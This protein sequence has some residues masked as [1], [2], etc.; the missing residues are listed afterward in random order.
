MNW[1]LGSAIFYAWFLLLPS[2]AFPA[3]AA[4]DPAVTSSTQGVA[5]GALQNIFQRFESLTSPGPL[6]QA[7]AGLDQPEGCGNCHPVVRGLSNEFCLVCH[8]SIGKRIENKIGLHGT[9]TGNC[10]T[11]H[12]EHKGRGRSLIKLDQKTFDH[13]STRYSLQGAHRTLAC[14][15]CHLSQKGSQP[16]YQIGLPA[17]CTTCHT[18]PHSANI[19]QDCTACHTQNGWRP[20]SPLKFNHQTQTRFPLQGR[21]LNATCEQCHKDPK[22]FRNTP[23][24]CDA[25]HAD[26]HA[27]QFK[28]QYCDACHSEAGFKRPSL[29]FNH[30]EMTRFTLT[31]R[32]AVVTCE[33]CHAGMKK[34]RVLTTCA[35]CHADPHKGQFGTSTACQT[36]HQ[37]EDWKGVNL[38]F[39][40]DANSRFPLT[41][42]HQEAVCAACHKEGQFR[43]TPT[44]CAS[45]HPNPHLGR[46]AETCEE[47]H[48]TAGFC[49][50]ALKF[51]HNLQTRFPLTGLHATR[52]CTKCH[53]DRSFSVRGA[54]C[55]TCHADSEGFYAGTLLTKIVPGKPDPM[56]G[57]VKCT[58]CH[59][60]TDP[61]ADPVLIRP[62]CIACHNPH[63]GNYFDESHQVLAERLK[64]LSPDLGKDPDK[65][66]AVEVIRHWGAH[67][68][69]YAIKLLDALSTSVPAAVRDQR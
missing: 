69:I 58:D 32:H 54:T 35:A 51:D 36:C 43:G 8:D 10:Y 30:S 25:C 56:H 22:A 12:K 67:N 45:C 50:E 17:G 26:P 6:N 19:S 59:K 29:K 64:R 65:K 5:A 47:C 18:A 42:K 15:A 53:A 2:L 55:D 57:S 14:A 34:F 28:G 1:S 23:S 9:Y 66:N 60:S 38:L 3:L 31:G 24:Q 21:H 13:D 33:R 11:C 62:R 46:Y 68:V 63:Y 16:H 48:S 40:H 7:H 52:D 4:D 61:K 41:G 37:S 49:G 20:A 27:D 44:R 39:R